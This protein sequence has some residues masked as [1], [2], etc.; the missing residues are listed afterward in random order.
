MDC[1]NEIRCKFQ[2]KHWVHSLNEFAAFTVEWI[3]RIDIAKTFFL[4]LY[5]FYLNALLYLF[6]IL[7]YG[8]MRKNDLIK[9]KCNKL[10]EV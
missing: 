5:F 2:V 7:L 6:H 3:D 8:F 10:G 4:H 9:E 1:G